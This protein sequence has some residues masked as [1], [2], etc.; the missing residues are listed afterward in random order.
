MKE[1][2]TVRRMVQRGGEILRWCEKKDAGGG[3]GSLLGKRKVEAETKKE[4]KK[5]APQLPGMEGSPAIINNGWMRNHAATIGCVVYLLVIRLAR[6]K[7]QSNRTS[8]FW[9]RSKTTSRPLD[10]AGSRGTRGKQ[11]ERSNSL[12]RG[13]MTPLQSHPSRSALKS[14]CTVAEA[15]K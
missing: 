2:S 14:T 7:C 12:P 3:I 9:N 10:N 6:F 13:V 8:K 15:T 1:G 5:S 4:R 11:C